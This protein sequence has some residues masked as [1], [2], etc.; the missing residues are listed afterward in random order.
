M[1]ILVV[2]D[3]QVVS[4]VMR[5][6]LTQE[7][8]CE[9][10]VAPDM[11]SAT[12]LLAEHEYFVAITDL[13][14]PDA[15]EGEIVKFVLAKQIPCIVLT[16]SWDAEQRARLLQ[17]GIVD[18]V[19]KENR[20]SYEYTAKLVKR[21]CRNQS[22]KVLVADDSVVSR[23]FIRSLLE[24]HLFQVIEADDGVSALETLNDNPDIKLLIT[25]Y[26]MPRLDGFGL[27]IKVREQL[28]REELAIIG[29]SSDSDESLSARF[30]KNGANDFLQKPF[31]HEEFH[32]RVLTTLDALDM[33]TKL[34]EQAN[35]DYLTN[36]Y[37]RRYFFNLYEDKLTNIAQKNSSLSL[38]LLDIDY[39]KKVNDNYGHD[40]GDEVL[41]EFARRLQQSF[42]QHFTVARIGGEEFV[43]GFKGLNVEKAYTLLDSFRMQLELT[44]ITTSK[45]LL[46]IT[47]STGVTEFTLDE[48]VDALLNR[49]DIGLYQAKQN[50]R[51]LVC[52]AQD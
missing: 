22:V 14:L 42:S 15:Q 30:I 9:V 4:R 32:C 29:L 33:V 2:E 38:A 28:S 5:H 46:N 12:A 48:N 26:N 49:A 52:I 19:F 39:F 35:L 18:Y 50:G 13:N 10:D 25:D 31:V 44:P 47:V 3:S 34:W 1:R 43:V 41:I 21:L 40:V 36:V 7:L 24:Q 27:I 45:G 23:K 6:L 11:Q 20:F 51:N 17:L 16:G 8:N 37:N